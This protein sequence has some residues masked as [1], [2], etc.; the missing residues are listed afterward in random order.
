MSGKGLSS[1]ATRKYAA[2]MAVA[3]LTLSLIAGVSYR[4]WE[5]HRRASAEVSRSRDIVDSV[6]R[7]LSSL[8]EADTGHRG[9]VFTGETRY[10]EPFDRATTAG[11][12]ELANLNRLLAGSPQQA[13][14]AQLRDLFD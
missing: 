5:V 8:N 1:I 4:E 10:L 7:L 12:A 14:V 11:P 13:E 2:P 6:S 3:V 9:F